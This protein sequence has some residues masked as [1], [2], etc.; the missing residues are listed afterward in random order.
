MAESQNIAQQEKLGAAVSSGDLD[1]L[2]DVF[3]AGCVDH[4]PAPGQ[5]QGPEGFKGFFSTMRA[6]F[7][8]FGVEVDKMVT[9]ED[10]VAIAYTI[11][12]THEGEFEGIAPTGRKVEVRGVQIGRFEDGKIV[13]R[14]GASNELAIL[15]Q[16]GAAPET[17]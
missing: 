15:Q 9:D 13:E 14:W 6:A 11:T 1:Q 10:N 16:L 3:A 7:P 12:G 8:D 5:Q 17:G 2:D 4:D